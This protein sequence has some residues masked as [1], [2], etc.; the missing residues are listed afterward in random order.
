LYINN[1]MHNKHFYL[2]LFLHLL[3]ALII[4]H[5]TIFFYRKLII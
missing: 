2:H 3:Q 5:R 1:L 4:M